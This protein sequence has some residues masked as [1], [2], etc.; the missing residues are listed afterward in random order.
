MAQP[1]RELGGEAQSREAYLLGLDPNLNIS[2]DFQTPTIGIDPT[3]GTSS[4]SWSG[5]TPTAGMNPGTSGTSPVY[6]GGQYYGGA[7]GTG[8][9]APAPMSTIGGPA[10]GPLSSG[11]NAIAA[12]QN[13]GSTSPGVAP[14][15]RW[16]NLIQTGQCQVA[17]FGSFSNPYNPSTFYEDPGYNFILGQGQQQIQNQQAT[18]GMALSPAALGAALNY[19]SGL[20]SQ[21]FN[22]A[23]QPRSL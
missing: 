7:A 10:V 22:N 3:T 5:G 6:F 4:L 18:T 16:R 11:I 21:E 19:S 13:G 9:G 12:Q 20:A 8:S 23:L 2:T 17:L 1:T 14:N 15:N